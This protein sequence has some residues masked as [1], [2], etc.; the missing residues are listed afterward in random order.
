LSEYQGGLEEVPLELGQ[1][2]LVLEPEEEA[3]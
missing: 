3:W 1:E 2:E